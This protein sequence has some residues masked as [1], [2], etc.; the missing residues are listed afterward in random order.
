MKRDRCDSDIDTD[1]AALAGPAAYSRRCGVGREFAVV[2][3]VVL[4]CPA[5]L[6]KFSQPGAA[7]GVLDGGDGD[8]W[9]RHCDSCKC[10]RQ[11][12][13]LEV[14]GVVAASGRNLV[15]WAGSG[16]G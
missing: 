16:G 4:G 3:G 14:V 9:E 15:P 7:C 13:P 10:V 12:R 11:A 1:G 6:H 5:C 2:G 8:G